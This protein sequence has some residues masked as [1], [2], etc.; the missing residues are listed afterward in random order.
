MEDQ[1]QPLKAEI[2]K[3][4]KQIQDLANERVQGAASDHGR[5]SLKGTECPDEH[6]LADII[7]SRVRDK[8]KAV[9][10]GIAS[11]FLQ[12][13]PESSPHQQLR[14]GRVTRFDKTS[15]QA[16]QGKEDDYEEDY[17]GEEA[18]E[19]QDLQLHDTNVESD[20]GCQFFTSTL[21]MSPESV[22]HE[23][24]LAQLKDVPSEF[25]LVRLEER[26]ENEIQLTGTMSEEKAKFDLYLSE[27]MT[28]MIP[29]EYQHHRFQREQEKKLF[30]PSTS[31]VALNSKL[32]RNIAPRVLEEEGFHIIHKP[33]VLEKNIHK[34]ENR[35]LMQEERKHWFGEDGNMIALPDPI[36]LSW[37]CRVPSPDNI[38]EDP[39]PGLETV[40][41][42][43]IVSEAAK[44][45]DG[46]FGEL[47][48]IYQLDINIANLHFLH[49]PLFSREHV[50]AAKLMQLYDNY[51]ARQKKNVSQLLID[52]LQTLNNT[53]KNLERNLEV[54]SINPSRIEDL[55]KQ[56]RET[57]RLLNME[58]EKDHTVLTSILK[59]WKQIKALRKVKTYT[60][61]SVK[62]QV[63]ELE[64]NYEALGK[65]CEVEYI[66]EVI[67]Q[68]QELQEQF[69]KEM[70]IYNE[71][72]KTFQ[73]QEKD[74]AMK[75]DESDNEYSV[76]DPG[77]PPKLST[78][79]NREKMEDMA[80][81][82]RAWIQGQRVKPI[83]IPK[84]SLTVDVTTTSECSGGELQRRTEMQDHKFFIS[85]FYNDKLVS[86]TVT[87]QLQ[88][89][90]S[91]QFGQIFNIQIIY[92]PESIRFEI[93]ELMNKNISLLAKVYI[94][95][96]EVTTITS[97]AVLEEIEFSSDEIVKTNHEGV[98]SN[99]PFSLDETKSE[100]YLLLTSGKLL[101]SVS[102]GVGKD[103][104][105]LAPPAPK[106]K[107]Y[108]E[109][110]DAIA[111][112]GMYWLNDLRK[113]TEWARKARVD[114]N[115]PQNSDLMQVIKYATDEGQ[116]APEYFRIEQIQEEFSF[117]SDKKLDLSK[118]FRLLMLRNAGVPEYCC[119][120]Q[121]P[122]YEREIADNIFQVINYVI[123]QNIKMEFEGQ[124]DDVFIITGE[125]SLTE[126]R[127]M[128]RKYLEKFAVMTSTSSEK[129]I[130]KLGEVFSHFGFPKQRQIS[131]AVISMI[132][133]RKALKPLRKERKKIPAQT[134][135]D[136]GIKLLI[137]V[138]GAYNIPVRKCITR[139]HQLHTLLSPTPGM[140]SN[141]HF[142][143]SEGEEDPF[144]QVQV[145]PFVEVTFQQT[146]YQTS[147]ADG[148]QPC[149]NE[150][151]E[152][153][154]KSP[155]GDYN[156]SALCKMK[157]KILINVYDNI[158]VSSPEVLVEFFN[159]EY[160]CRSFFFNVA[161]FASPDSQGPKHIHNW[162][163]ITVWPPM[164]QTAPI[165]YGDTSQIDCLETC[166]LKPNVKHWL[167][168][169]AIPFN[170]VLEQSKISGTFRIESPPMLLGYTWKKIDT[171]S[172]E[173]FYEFGLAESSLLT[174]FM[175]LDP[176]V[177]CSDSVSPQFETIE[178][179][180][181]LH[182][183]YAF[184]KEI[185]TL[186]P[187]RRIIVSVIDTDC[188]VGIVTRYIRPLHP[189][190]ELLDTFPDNPEA[191]FNLIARFVSLIP[192]LPDSL[193][194]SDSC[195]VW[196]TSQQF[197]NLILG[198]KE[199]HAILLCNYF[200]YM[201]VNAF[202]ILGTSILEGPT[203][204]VVT[205]EKLHTM[206]WNPETG[207]CYDQYNA[208]CPLQS[209]DCLINNDNIWVNIQ[210]A[211]LPMSVNFD[212]SKEYNWKPFFIKSSQHHALSSVQPP[213]LIYYS[214]ERSMVDKLQN[215][216]EWA[217]KSK[218]MDWRAQQPTRWNRYCTGVFQNFLPLLEQN[219]GRSVSEEQS[220]AL[221]SLLKDFKISGF[222]L[223]MHYSDMETIFDK[224]YNTG[225]HHIEIP[226][227]EF[228]VAV[229]V[230]AYPNNALSVWIYVASL[231]H[232]T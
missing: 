114:P 188:R 48:E 165:P 141:V 12:E 69:R 179:E 139:P 106:P 36:K 142:R 85:I 52:K 57:K 73:N 157:D 124:R 92:K 64:V 80:R 72:L 18:V 16:L 71:K 54:N 147:I 46:Y 155:N 148:T 89:D 158:N 172:C 98:G 8:L 182:K 82:R 111:S 189:P 4:K 109:S 174:I 176:Q 87:S 202:I 75:E 154:F 163:F 117:V 178:D 49:H 62:L 198:G 86:S 205:Q 199:D 224:V 230:H 206:I 53:I 99:I 225:I 45:V 30:V 180:E 170:T 14:D 153:E 29:A 76:D 70:E 171:G 194:F 37:K 31:P 107:T 113:L 13:L 24:E 59:V 211:N 222:P 195:N 212:V 138:I 128:A 146:M 135:S 217:L 116:D 175:T 7:R 186:Y 1:I 120:K 132:A 91:V 162:A 65:Q 134:L 60:C 93:Y 187:K 103:G 123:S 11:A 221:E 110:M 231:V 67:E 190:Q 23:H 140:T 97:T 108:K 125:D 77:T 164:C 143:K 122:P 229:Y 156:S 90:F 50:M 33:D 10:V 213:E 19:D 166:N 173:Q 42:K 121:V 58:K 209:A 5:M 159:S 68:E 218:I 167:G 9:K 177:S 17:T 144:N 47:S 35:F 28:E 200:L 192:Y 133:P 100:E 129:T 55:K 26:E 204:Y 168:S 183:A 2:K 41:R 220:T 39:K 127:M 104:I 137:N 83:L 38:V 119:F 197:L 228:A 32:P 115:D 130:E 227:V 161:V 44:A 66:A 20:E 27:H 25:H 94:P 131:L 126:Q 169:I 61:T 150:K 203:A 232:D 152:I 181:M 34:M 223:Q 81:K 96:P 208:F 74:K 201:K 191:T 101:Y 15:Q 219:L 56:I 149:W 102:W 185:R 214:T 193:G 51:Q 226:N 112:I 40:Y 196:L 136:G 22:T 151:L 145:Q 3:S 216:I 21:D 84:L 215:R 95:I 63:Q 6:H 160:H 207:E 88:S 210:K 43:A 184:Q 79:T 105:A 78:P 118:R